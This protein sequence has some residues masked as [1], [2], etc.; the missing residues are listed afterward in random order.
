MSFYSIFSTD[1][2]LESGEGITLDYGAAG[3]IRIHRAGG[4][5]KRYGKILDCKLRPYR[6]QIENA[7]IDEKVAARLM[8]EAYAEGVVVGWEDVVDQDG[9]IMPFTVENCVKLFLD[10]PELFADVQEQANRVSNF[11]KAQLQDDLGNSATA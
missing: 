5:N 11:R 1:P 7:S 3:R 4:S 9:N 2:N 6:R 10:L 8:A